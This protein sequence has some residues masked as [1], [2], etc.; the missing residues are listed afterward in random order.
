[1]LNSRNTS[2]ELL[3]GKLE[4]FFKWFVECQII[5][6]DERK[7][8]PTQPKKSIIGD[9]VYKEI[10]E[11]VNQ[12]VDPNIEHYKIKN[13]VNGKDRKLSPRVRRMIAA[14]WFLVNFFDCTIKGGF[15]RDWIVNGEDII[16]PG[17]DLKNLLQPNARNRFLEVA[18]EMIT[19]SDIDV[20]LP[21]DRIFNPEQFTMEMSKLGISVAIEDDGWRKHLMFD[22]GRETGGFTADLIQP[23][24]YI[25]HDNYDFDVNVFYIEKDHLNQIGMK[26]PIVLRPLSRNGQLLAF[27]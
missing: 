4:A 8:A 1:V 15:V 24:C 21:N 25:C 5:C 11:R 2:I 18:D 14:C 19:P 27:N 13:M 22:Y 16:P 6:T 26:M 17:T 7:L 9:T 10:T 3:K 12:I 23:Y 20:E